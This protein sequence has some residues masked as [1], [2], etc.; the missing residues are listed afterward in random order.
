M[1]N[2]MLPAEHYPFRIAVDRL[3][4]F[5][6]NWAWIPPYL[7]FWSVCLGVFFIT[8]FFLWLFWYHLQNN[9]QEVMS[10]NIFRIS[11]FHPLTLQPTQILQGRKSEN[12]GL[13]STCRPLNWIM[14]PCKWCSAAYLSGAYTFNTLPNLELLTT[15]K[16]LF[17]LALQ[18]P[19]PLVEPK[20][21][22]GIVKGSSP[23]T[24][25][26]YSIN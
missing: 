8:F 12:N 6:G 13:P 3:G 16:L 2:R 15:S 7:S 14:L 26:Y 22:V 17:C 11:R 23:N 9:S 4:V 21:R 19:S 25:G 20:K 1:E 24:D 10:L 5:P 18:S